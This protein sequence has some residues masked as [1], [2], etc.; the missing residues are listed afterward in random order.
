MKDSL[1]TI[2]VCEW[3]IGVKEVEAMLKKFK[4]DTVKVIDEFVYPLKYLI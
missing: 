4:L 2:G 3:D 1:N